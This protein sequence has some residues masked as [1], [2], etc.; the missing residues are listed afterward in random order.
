MH[1]DVRKADCL[2]A[3]DTS[4]SAPILFFLVFHYTVPGNTCSVLIDDLLLD[5]D[6]LPVMSSLCDHVPYM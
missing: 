5:K 3:L 1:E 6:N 2:C 4:V